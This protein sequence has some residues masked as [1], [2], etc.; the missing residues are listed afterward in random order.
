MTF[1]LQIEF[2]GVSSS[3]PH[4]IDRKLCVPVKCKSLRL[5]RVLFCSSNLFLPLPI[6]STNPF[7][8][9]RTFSESWITMAILEHSGSFLR[10]HPFV[11]Q[12]YFYIGMNFFLNFFN[13]IYWQN[14]AKNVLAK[15]GLNLFKFSNANLQY[16]LPVLNK[17]MTLNRLPRYP[18]PLLPLHACIFLVVFPNLISLHVILLGFGVWPQ[19][20]TRVDGIAWPREIDM[21]ECVATKSKLINGS[22][23]CCFWFCY[24]QFNCIVKCKL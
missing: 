19:Y 17:S 4:P 24:M 23:K 14:R 12:K 6:F 3:F 11:F 16:F 2:A 7:C 8:F 13:Q 21:R 10:L 22:W 20:E 15:S 9:W 1:P 5:C 18:I